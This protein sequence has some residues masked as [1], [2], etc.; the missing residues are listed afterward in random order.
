MF[1]ND[2]INF[3]NSDL[4]LP[5]GKHAVSTTYRVTPDRDA[6]LENISDANSIK[7]K[8][9]VVSSAKMDSSDPENSSTNITELFCVVNV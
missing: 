9:V 5:N 1:T 3:D 6:A 8:P 4:N 2:Q 7:K